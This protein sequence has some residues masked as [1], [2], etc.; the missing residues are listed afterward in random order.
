MHHV[1]LLARYRPQPMVCIARRMA[2]SSPG[3]IRLSNDGRPQ[4]AS[5]RAAAAAFLRSMRAFIMAFGA[6]WKVIMHL[7]TRFFL[8]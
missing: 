1:Q 6:Q 2:R 7:P 4:F 3:G 5:G 8:P